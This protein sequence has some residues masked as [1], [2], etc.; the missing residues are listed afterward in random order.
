M[1]LSPWNTWVKWE[2]DNFPHGKSAV[3]LTNEVND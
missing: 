2:P 1:I 3:L